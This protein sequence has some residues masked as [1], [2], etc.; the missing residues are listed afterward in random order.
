[1][2]IAWLV[3]TMVSGPLASY[4]FRGVVLELAACM[5][6]YSHRVPCRCTTFAPMRAKED[7]KSVLRYI[8]YGINAPR[9]WHLTTP[10]NRRKQRHFI[11]WLYVPR[12]LS[13]E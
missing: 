13:I 11:Q 7:C 3:S 2:Y 4:G 5:Y 6:I 8:V 1:M 12:K 9:A 10:N